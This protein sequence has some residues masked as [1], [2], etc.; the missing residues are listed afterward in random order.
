MKPLWLQT[1][2]RYIGM[3][4][5]PS[6]CLGFS[7]SLQA[8]ATGGVTPSHVFQ[9]TQ[10]IIEEI[11]ILRDTIGLTDTPLEPDEQK[12]KSPIHVYTKGLELLEKVSRAERKLGMAPAEVGELPLK[13]ITPTDV[14]ILADSILLELGKMKQQLAIDGKAPKIK[15]VG[16]KT[17]SHVYT[18][19]WRASY[20]MDGLTG[21]LTPND[22]FRNVQYI[23]D[24]M[25]LIATNMNVE[26]DLESTKADSRKSPKDVAQQG[27]LALYKIAALQ[28]RLGMD[29]TGVPSFTLVRI[30][31][32]DVYDITNMLLAEVLRIKIFLEIPLP[33]GSHPALIGKT[34]TDV[35]A[36]MKLVADNMNKLTKAATKQKK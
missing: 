34:P 2:V 25:E 16:G 9:K 11:Y 1:P 29:S 26:L 27:M 35:Y 24:E 15:F 31:P 13:K 20:M 19:M 30:T 22:V 14:A 3:A 36:E 4:L 28:R 7:S 5:I 17:P 21:K 33:R 23:Q 18:N 8:E 32:S 6:I 12:S 10:Q